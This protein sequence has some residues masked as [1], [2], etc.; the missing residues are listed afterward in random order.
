MLR[1]FDG[2]TWAHIL[3]TATV[4]GELENGTSELHLIGIHVA[5]REQVEGKR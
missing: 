5:A 4:P 3:A 2:L 1:S